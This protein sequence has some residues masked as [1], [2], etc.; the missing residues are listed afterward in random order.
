MKQLD[1]I[2]TAASCQFPRDGIECGKTAVHELYGMYFCEGCAY[3]AYY[4]M[5]GVQAKRVKG[6]GQA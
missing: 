4:V 5:G 6:V 2:D 3:W 1:L